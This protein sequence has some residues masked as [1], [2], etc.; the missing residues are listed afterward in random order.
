[1]KSRHILALSFVAIFPAFQA[2]AYDVGDRFTC[3]VGSG[4]WSA[5]EYNW[6]QYAQEPFIFDL[7]VVSQNSIVI[8]SEHYFDQAKRT[9]RYNV[10]DHLEAESMNGTFIL[11]DGEFTYT[12][13]TH[14][15]VS[16]MQGDCTKI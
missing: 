8:Y 6:S 14:I 2:F 4:S 9:I 1:M 3:I 12:S 5:K 15:S 13:I 16:Y 7:R 11:T 10:G